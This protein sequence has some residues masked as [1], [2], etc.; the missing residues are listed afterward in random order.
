MQNPASCLDDSL[1]FF[2]LRT[3]EAE[4]NL[5]G[6]PWDPSPPSLSP[7]L[8]LLQMKAPFLSADTC[9]WTYWL[10]SREQLSLSSV[11]VTSRKRPRCSVENISLAALESRPRSS[12]Q[13]RTVEQTG[14]QSRETGNGAHP[15][16][17]IQNNVQGRAKWGPR[18]RIQSQ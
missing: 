18:A 14:S 15:T 5:Q 16:R 2:P 13:T 8:P 3:A 4:Q 9:L 6:W 11:T 17:V 1:R 12:R 7:S 10:L